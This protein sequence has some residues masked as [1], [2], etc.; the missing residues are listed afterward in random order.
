MAE[1][2]KPKIAVLLVGGHSR[3]MGFDKH[4]LKVNSK[5]QWRFMLDELSLFF[6]EVYISCRPDQQELFKGERLI[7]DTAGDIGPMGALYSSFQTVNADQIFFVACD[8]PHFRISLAEQLYTKLDVSCDV[9]AA[10]SAH[11]S[12]PE[13][14]VAI[15]NRSVLPHL[16]QCKQEGNYA[17]YRCMKALSVQSLPVKDDRMIQN[18][19]RPEDLKSI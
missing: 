8:L 12:Y 5:S 13:P 14:L 18:V 19:N 3:R 4:D 1:L 2:K 10:Q 17:L 16:T 9:C 15:W 7:L 6:D 11:K